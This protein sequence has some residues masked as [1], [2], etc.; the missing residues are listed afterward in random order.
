MFRNSIRQ[1]IVGI[2]AGLIVLAVIT[3][4]LSMVMAGQVGHLL[5]ELTNR[6]IPAYGHLARVNIRSLERSL[7]MRRMMMAK[8]QAPGEASGYDAARKT[9]DEIEPTIKREAD[10][11]RVLIDS[12]I[13]DPSTPSDNAALGR[14]DDRIDNAV[15]DLLMRL[16]AENK[17][18]LDQL[19]AQDFAAAKATTLRADVLRDDFNNKIEG[20]RTDMLAQVAS[21]AAKVMSA[22]QRAIIISGVVTAIAAI[23]GF[24]FAMLVGSG[25]TRPVMRLLEGTREVE[26]G[27]L[28]GTIA[29]TTQDEIGQLSAA[30]NRMIETLRHNQRI[31]ETFG[32]Y[33]NPRIAEGL[34]EQPAIA[35]TEGQR[36]IMTVM[37]CDMK[38][39]TSLSEGVTPR[40]LVKIMNLYLSTM[41]APVHAHRGIIDKYIGDAIMAYWGAP[42]VE[43]AEQTHLAALAAIDMIGQVNQLR[44]DLPELLGVRAIPADCDIRIG[45]ATGEVLVG[46]IGSEFMMSYTVLGDT[47]NLASRL[48]GANKF[49]GS[50]SLISEATASACAAT[51]ELREIDRLV[52]VGQTQ[53]VAVFE[54]LGKKDQLTPAQTELRQR[55]ADGLAAYRDRRWDDAEQA[56]TA[57][58]AAAPGDGPSIA[59]KARVAAFRQNLPAAD[60]DGAWYLEQK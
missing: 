40:G 47:V 57:A 5:D 23:L 41:S 43:E 26:A 36:R 52:A 24:V 49:Y 59:M 34:L 28:D 18:L 16:N 50:R 11:A 2:A 30:F 17:T 20:I 29:I 53:P 6:Y 15:N 32:R 12:I 33:I 44:K 35:A 8:M 25:I 3:S 38:G 45:I 46:S 48:E 22:Q 4:L 51:I 27:R 1:K 58:L 39:F 7:A 21:A 54:I 31:R 56:F 19:D 13:A 37:F 60:W 14:L 55:Y 10:A 42:F 9:F